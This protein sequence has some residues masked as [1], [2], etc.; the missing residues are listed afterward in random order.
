MCTWFERGIVYINDLLNPPLPGKLFEELVLD[1]YISR[2]DRRE[3]NFLMNCIPSLWLQDLYLYLYLYLYFII[4][5]QH[6]GPKAKLHV[7]TY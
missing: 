1:F 4:H 6:S 7:F 3:F 5:T 2:Y